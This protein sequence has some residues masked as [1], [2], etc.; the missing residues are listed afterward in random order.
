MMPV[1]MKATISGWRS[2]RPMIPMV[3]ASANSAA[4]S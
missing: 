4:S 3:A 1:A 2:N